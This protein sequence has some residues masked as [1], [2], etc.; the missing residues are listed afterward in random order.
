MTKIQKIPFNN[1]LGKICRELNTGTYKMGDNILNG[2]Y[3]ETSS[4]YKIF[5][6]HE[7]DRKNAG[8][9]YLSPTGK[10]LQPFFLM[11]KFGLISKNNIS[12]EMLGNLE[13]D[14]LAEGFKGVLALYGAGFNVCSIGGCQG[15]PKTLEILNNWGIPVTKYINKVFADT[16]IVTNPQVASGYRTLLEQCSAAELFVF[17]PPEIISISDTGD[18]FFDKSSPDDWLQN[19][20]TMEI[21]LQK[22]KKVNIDSIETFHQNF[23]VK[24]Q[25]KTDSKYTVNKQ[26]TEWLR[27]FFQNRL[28]YISETN[29]YYF[30]IDTGYWEAL[31]FK[32]L[33]DRVLAACES[34]WTYSALESSVVG[35]KFL[36]PLK[37]AQKLF[38]TRKYIGF[39]N[40][41][42][43]LEDQT[44]L[45][46]DPKYYIGGLL[47]FNFVQE[48]SPVL[49]KIC[50]KLCSWISDRVDD[51]EILINILLCFLYM[52]ILNVRNPERFLFLSGYSSSGKSTFLNLL[53][54]LVPEN[55]VYATAA[56]DLSSQFGLQE[57]TGIAKTLI[58][59]HDIGSLF[60]LLFL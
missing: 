60:G 27:S 30:Y 56:E 10:G 31:T 1:W 47:P 16:D 59:C 18:L 42:W 26:I 49:R 40:G 7:E 43:D 4:D 38:E 53:E 36:K 35:P 5:M 57:L 23:S 15:G 9:K 19:G 45:A 8:V 33:F 54:K 58:I 39:K 6:V 11:Q 44:L 55:R 13:K 12:Q 34:D 28:I 41:V 3:I 52:S 46:H 48:E 21:T 2:W 29:Q 37:D 25:R 50:P 24:I 17:P 22:V 32:T 51:D 20:D 14:G